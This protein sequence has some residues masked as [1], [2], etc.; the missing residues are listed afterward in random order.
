MHGFIMNVAF[1]SVMHFSVEYVSI[2]LNLCACATDLH[3]QKK[4]KKKN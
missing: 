3:S 1:E 2:I 4:E